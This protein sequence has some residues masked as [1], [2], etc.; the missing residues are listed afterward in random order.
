MQVNGKVRATAVVPADADRDA[1]EAA[2]LADERVVR[3]VAGA[4]IK[5]V[6]V[7]PGRLVNIVVG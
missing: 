3:A 4:P 7:V 5:R 1:V 2:V 6:V